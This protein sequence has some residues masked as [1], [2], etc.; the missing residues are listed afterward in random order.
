MTGIL[1]DSPSMLT[2]FHPLIIML[3]KPS[4]GIFL[5]ISKTILGINSRN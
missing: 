3:F 4:S 5:N 2:R 1:E